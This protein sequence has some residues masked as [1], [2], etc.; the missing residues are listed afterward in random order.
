M[1]RRN[2]LSDILGN[3]LGFQSSLTDRDVWFKVESDKTAIENY[4]YILVNV[5][6]FLIADKDPQKYI[7]MLE[8]K[9]TVKTS[10]IG[11]PKVY[12]GV[13]VDKLLY[14]DGFYVWKMISDSYVKEEVNNAKNKIKGDGLEY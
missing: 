6:D 13:D 9:Y 8:S 1:A 14:C 5:D 2:H 12:L 3:H 7:A 4:T 10:S 11:E